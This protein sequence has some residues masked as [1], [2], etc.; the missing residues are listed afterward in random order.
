[1]DITMTQLFNAK[2]R[3]LTEWR[4]IFEEADERFAFIGGK[5]PTGSILWIIEVVW[6]P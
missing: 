1:M 6:K 2:E 3:E 4:A 5:Q